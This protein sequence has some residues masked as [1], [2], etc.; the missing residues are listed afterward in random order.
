ML[1]VEAGPRRATRLPDG[2]E[3]VAPTRFALTPLTP[4]IGAE[5]AGVDLRQPLDDVTRAELHRALLEW[6]VLFLRDQPITGE[7]HRAF[8]RT[9]GELEIHPFLPQGEVPEIVRF[10][11]GDDQKGTE[12]IWHSD[13][14]WREIPSLGSIL[15][16]VECPAVGGDTLWADMGAAYDLLPDDLKE[17]IDGLD[18]VHDFAHNFGRAMAP[19]QIATFR[20]QFPPATHPVVRAHPETGRKTLYV[21]EIFTSHVVGLDAAESDALLDRLCRQ[22]RIP[23]IQCR[24]RW[25]PDAIAVWDNRATQHYAASD[26]WPARRVME[27]ATVIGDAPHR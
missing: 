17:R 3:P 26:Y 11:K 16:C 7:Q 9:W 12:N 21:N 23:E 4:L 10:E 13:V 18:A 19:E 15:R 20:E 5:V 25:S 8:A 27:R 2:W 14:S 22:S 6:K 24:F 1:T